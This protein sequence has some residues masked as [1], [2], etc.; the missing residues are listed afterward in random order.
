[1]N[2][3]DIRWQQRFTNYSNALGHLKNAFLLESPNEF[4][5]AGAIQFFEMSMELAWKVLKDFLEAEGILVRSPR[6]TFKQALQNALI[7]DGEQ[8]LKAWDD[9]NLTTH[10]YSEEAAEALFQR[11]QEKYLV[12][13]SQLHDCLS[14]KI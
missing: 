1:M 6:E 13:L 2:A 14:S 7:D 5:R 3:K 11:I 4:E 9:R 8:W 10:M 12:R